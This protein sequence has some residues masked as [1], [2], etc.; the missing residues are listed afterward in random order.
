MVSMYLECRSYEKERK[1]G[2]ND[3]N[4]ALTKMHN[5]VI[6]SSYSLLLVGIIIL[7]GIGSFYVFKYKMA[8]LLF[9]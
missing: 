5:D 6:N 8:I 2:K 4:A 3:R 7:F 9:S 1:K